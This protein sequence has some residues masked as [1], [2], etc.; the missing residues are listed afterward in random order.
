MVQVVMNRNERGEDGTTWRFGLT[1]NPSAAF[2]NWLVGIGAA[3]ALDGSIV[4][5]GGGVTGS[6]AAKLDKLQPEASIASATTTDLGAASTEEV[7]ITG[8][9]TITGF[10][11]AA[12]GTRRC[13]RF[14]G[15]L[16]LTHN[17]TSLQLPSNANIT[18]QAGDRFTAVSQG[19]GNWIVKTYTRAGGAPVQPPW[20]PGLPPNGY[21][22]PGDRITRDDWPYYGI[23]AR[24]TGGVWANEPETTYTLATL[25]TASAQL[26]GI[27]LTLADLCKYSNGNFSKALVQVNQM[28]DGG[29]YWTG[30]GKAPL[31]LFTGRNL[32]VINTDGT[33]NGLDQTVE[34]ITLPNRA[35]FYPP[36]MDLVF[37]LHGIL[38]THGAGDTALTK[39]ID[40]TTGTIVVNQTIASGGTINAIRAPL[41]VSDTVGSQFQVGNSVSSTGYIISSV[42]DSTRAW[43]LPGR[44]MRFAQNLPATSK[45]SWRQRDVTFVYR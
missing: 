1:Y 34:D 36:N 38:T 8:T 13:G 9:T 28:G 5:I 35:D 45:M 32:L 6:D 19:G 25:P 41:R 39:L 11:A 12:A 4:D 40:V 27:A 15:A 3:Y 21:G 14:A 22:A 44:V 43:S 29:Y 18:T 2:A 26:E 23:I 10:G 24:N 37:E 31:P 42:A 30:Y 20:Y 7:L 17:G 33:G 16:T